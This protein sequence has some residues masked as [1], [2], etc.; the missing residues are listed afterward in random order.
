V[1]EVEIKTTRRGRVGRT[2]GTQVESKEEEEKTGQLEE[3]SLDSPKRKTRRGSSSK[4]TV[5]ISEKEESVGAEKS[6]PTKVT[7]RAQAED[8]AATME[9][10]NDASKALPSAIKN[11]GGK[12]RKSTTKEENNAGDEVEGGKEDV[13][14][15][16]TVPTKVTRKG[17]KG[18]VQMEAK[19]EI[20]KDISEPVASVDTPSG[21]SS[22]SESKAKPGKDKGAAAKQ[23]PS[24]IVADETVQQGL[25]DTDGSKKVLKKTKT[26]KSLSVQR[27]GTVKIFSARRKR[28]CRTESSD[29]LRKVMKKKIVKPKMEKTAA[30]QIVSKIKSDNEDSKTIPKAE[31]PLLESSSP[32]SLEKSTPKT[33]GALHKKK[34][35]VKV[36]KNISKKSNTGGEAEEKEVNSPKRDV[37]PPMSSKKPQRTSSIDSS[38]EPQEKKVGA[39]KKATEV[40]KPKRTVSTETKSSPQSKKE[41]SVTEKSKNPKRDLS[42]DSK[43]EE[44]EEKESKKKVAKK[45][46]DDESSSIL[47]KGK[48]SVKGKGSAQTLPDSK[49]VVTNKKP[50]KKNEEA[51]SNPKGSKSKDEQGADKDGEKKVI[52]KKITNEAAK[53]VKKKQ[54]EKEKDTKA[55]TTASKKDVET[56]KAKDEGKKE[57]KVAKKNE[58]NDST[59]T[60]TAP[61]PAAGKLKDGT[62]KNSKPASTSKNAVKTNIEAKQT[63]SEETAKGVKRKHQEV[64]HNTKETKSDSKKAKPTLSKKRTRANA[65]STRSINIKGVEKQNV[66]TTKSPTKKKPQAAK[67]AP[68]DDL[69]QTPLSQNEKQEKPAKATKKDAKRVKVDDEISFKSPKV[70]KTTVEKPVTAAKKGKTSQADQVVEGG[71]PVMKLLQA[72]GRKLGI[73]KK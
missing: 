43:E 30:L 41:E 7:K 18:K 71:S 45:S 4:E 29:P 3:K 57:K 64:D 24:K 13:E 8:K 1:V 6:S 47:R 56:S 73:L 23:D 44:N 28:D 37:P 16:E 2:Q 58:K 66:Q 20:M 26:G 55:K 11:Q 31:I 69:S 40:Q 22:N 39:T 62:K 61:S 5:V 49:A 65:P 9:T 38:K 25:E 72:A 48:Q 17:G 70:S 54:P 68:A 51:L 50:E 59:T 27:L 33:I 36:V 67:A 46:K 19:E 21:K 63:E 35:K 15:P 32:L 10:T 12:K 60:V 14:K 34:P 52:G 53:A 42:K